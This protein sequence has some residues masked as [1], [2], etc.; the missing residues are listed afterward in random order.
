MKST[1]DAYDDDKPLMLG[2]ADTVNAIDIIQQR[3]Q[4]DV[5]RLKAFWEG[6]WNL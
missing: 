4:V 2:S 3:T 1:R 6:V 5:Q